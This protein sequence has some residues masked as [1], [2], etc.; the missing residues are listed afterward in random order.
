MDCYS[1]V[2]CTKFCVSRNK[3]LQSISWEV[4]WQIIKNILESLHY[5]L[6]LC[7]YFCSKS[8]QLYEEEFFRKNAFPSNFSTCRVSY[9]RKDSCTKLSLFAKNPLILYMVIFICLLH[10]Y[11]YLWMKYLP[12]CSYALLKVIFLWKNKIFQVG[13]SVQTMQKE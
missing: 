13:V 9:K 7:N 3:L 10:I 8:V 2:G 4:L 5:C 6:F 11:P 1:F 12:W